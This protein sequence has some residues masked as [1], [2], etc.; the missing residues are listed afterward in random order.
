MA[1]K[2]AS[3]K[4][5]AK[6]GS[7]SHAAHSMLAAPKRTKNTRRRK[8]RSILGFLFKWTFILG[9]WGM[10]GLAGILAWYAQDLP[11]ITNTAAFERKSSIIVKAADG[12]T[13]ARYGELKGKSVS[14]NDLPPYLVE[15]VIA[16]EDRR[17]YSHP[18]VDILGIARAMATNLLKGRLVQ[19]G[20]T[21]TQQLAKNL[22]LTHDRKLKRKIQEAMLALWLERELTKDEILSAYLN[23]V[24]LGSGVY[25]VNAA[26]QLYFGKPASAVNLQESAVL[27]GLLK[28]PSTYSP[29]NN[30]DLAKKRADTV[31]AAM[32][33]AGYITKEQ[34]KTASAPMVPSPRTKPTGEKAIRYFADWVVDGLDD[35]VGT[36]D[37]D[38]I[39]QTTIDPGIQTKA[40]ESLIRV[41]LEN[42]ADRDVSQGAVLVMRPDGAVLAMVGGR[43]YSASQFNRTTQARRAPGSSFK[44]IV[45]L[46][47]L[48]EGWQP[49]ATILDAPITEGDYRPKN[50]GN[51]YKG[52]V[53]LTEALTYS[54]NTVAVRL[55]KDVGPQSVITTARKLGIISPLQPDLSL[56][57]G[58]SGVS[59]LE[60][61][62]AYA[63]LA[64]GGRRVYPFAITEIKNAEGRLLYM[65]KAPTSY[66]QILP[67]RAVQTLSAMMQSVIDNGTGRGARLP[68]PASGKTG[69]SQD[70]RDAWFMGFTDRVVTGVWLGNDDNSPMKK[71]TGG[72]LPAI[73]WRDVMTYANPRIDPSM[74]ATSGS[75]NTYS[76]NGGSFQNL[77]NRII[78]TGAPIEKTGPVDYSRMNE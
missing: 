15:A 26:A 28:A 52:E 75:F 32:V 8:R 34:A 72:S 10:L 4:S 42:G 35:L 59:M 57:L 24:Y 3:K 40:E 48:L 60:M 78:P 39:V 74:P 66:E 53:T 65:R 58:S 46:T 6:S 20:S 31:L 49:N 11:D 7:K 1:K 69:T 73:I 67:P 61:D 47:A 38:L 71:V 27:A 19:G 62:T 37:M 44:P 76:N 21:I 77:L 68:F 70:S 36:P 5:K 14:V 55:M 22:F 30:P 64:N 12:S 41:L 29:L 9:I 17:F 23:R 50:F 16:T 54:L 18:G 45:Y 56:A 43:D 13:I 63:V 33:D 51:E 2:T 25:G